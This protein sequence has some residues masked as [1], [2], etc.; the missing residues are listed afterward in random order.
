MSMKV[1]LVFCESLLPEGFHM[2]VL[3]VCRDIKDAV[4][5]I[6]SE[7]HDHCIQMDKGDFP[8][9]EDYK[10]DTE[11]DDDGNIEYLKIISESNPEYYIEYYIEE[12]ELL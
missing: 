6:G 12:K 5:C 3:E 1:Y 11:Y 7:W 10:E 8:H 4:N 9:F 2:D